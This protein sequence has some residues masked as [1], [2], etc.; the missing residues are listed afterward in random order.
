MKKLKLNIFSIENREESHD[1]LSLFQFVNQN[2]QVNEPVCLE[3]S[4]Y[5]FELNAVLKVCDSES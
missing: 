3:F 4:S 2:S 5:V 1:K